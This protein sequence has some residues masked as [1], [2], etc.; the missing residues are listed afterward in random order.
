M[1]D[2]EYASQWARRIFEMNLPYASLRH[3]GSDEYVLR[4]NPHKM[5]PVYDQYN[6]QYI[7]ISE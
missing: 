1:L 3:I 5:F 7:S 2:G 6:M 4:I